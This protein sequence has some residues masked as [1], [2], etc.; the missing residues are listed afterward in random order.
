[1][2]IS[3]AI[4]LICVA[5]VVGFII[6]FIFFNIR[7]NRNEVVGQ[8]EIIKESENDRPYMYLQVSKPDILLHTGKRFVF[9]RVR[10]LKYNDRTDIIK[11]TDS[12]K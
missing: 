6:G 10:R 11:N 9:L 8:L 3:I 5:L 2:S 7:R 4:V 1:M 12:Q